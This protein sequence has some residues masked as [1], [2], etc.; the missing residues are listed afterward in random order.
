MIF[1]DIPFT[2]EQ[3]RYL[4][5]H[6]ADHTILELAKHLTRTPGSIRSRLTKLKIKRNKTKV[7]RSRWTIEEDNIVINNTDKSIIEMTELLPNRTPTAIEIRRKTLNLQSPRPKALQN[8]NGE[9][10]C[11]VCKQWK[12]ESEMK[13]HVICKIDYTEREA[14]FFK[15]N[16]NRYLRKTWTTIV[17]RANSRNLSCTITTDD[18]IELYKKQN[19]K[20]FFTGTE[21]TIRDKNKETDLSVDR[22][23]SS[24]GY[25]LWNICLVTYEVN[26]RKNNASLRF[27]KNEWDKWY[28][29]IIKDLEEKKID[30][31]KYL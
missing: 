10:F 31:T 27:I 19:G 29:T 22:L 14:V 1:E 18:I 15:K 21:L 17:N 28:Q 8:E 23:I 9:F 12:P 20:C 24:E 6:G 13:D 2:E 7:S 11:H 30:Y 26:T 3:D 16:I 25:E 4:L 5:E